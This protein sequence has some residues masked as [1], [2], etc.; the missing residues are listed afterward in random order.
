MSAMPFSC[1][2]TALLLFVTGILLYALP[3]ARHDLWN[4]DEP[5]NAEIAREMAAT[6]DWFIPKLNGKPFLEEPPLQHWL[7]ITVGGGRV[8]AWAARMPAAVSASL[9]LAITFLLGAWLFSRWVG[10]AAALFLSTAFEF[11]WLAGRAQVDLLLTASVLLAVSGFAAS[12][13]F[14]ERRVAGLVVFYLASAVGFLA[15]GLLGPGLPGLAVVTYLLWEKGSLRG[16]GTHLVVGSLFLLAVI[17]GWAA[18]LSSHGGA[19]SVSEYFVKQHLQRFTGGQ[20]HQAPFWYYLPVFPL[21][22]LPWTL[23]APAAILGLRGA[24]G[25]E[26]KDA[27]WLR[28]L[29][30]WFLSGFLVFSA[31]STKRETY[32]VPILPAAALLFAAGL[33]RAWDRFPVRRFLREREI[34]FGVAG[35]I[36]AGGVVVIPIVWGV[37]RWKPDAIAIASLLAAAAVLA[38]GFRPSRWR[39]GTAFPLALP[40]LVAMGFWA[41]SMAAFPAVDVRK[42]ARPL[43]D[44]IRR[45]A[46]PQGRVSFYRASEGMVGAYT[47]YLGCLIPN[48]YR[49]DEIQR[50]LASPGQV[51]FILNAKDLPG[52]ARAGGVA[53]STVAEERVG[54]RRILVVEA[55]RPR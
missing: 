40:A 22:F 16:H 20:D 4:P 45:A 23:L 19:G 11:W 50:T 47:F 31:A 3:A 17:L 35:A 9:A 34:T 32:L 10:V 1:T 5:R 33:E 21:V 48:L 41:V 14:P 46:E 38:R 13:R 7:V 52:L 26:K 36:L 8:S 6:Q 55:S 51:L 25:R 39:V 53:F 49:A 44:A 54:H 30:G 18:I 27:R 43:T 29:A 2:R 12:E 37:F 42:S 24:F 28:L 15:K